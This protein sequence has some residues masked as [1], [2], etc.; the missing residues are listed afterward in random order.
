MWAQ[1]ADALTLDFEQTNILQI[2]THLEEAT[3]LKEGGVGQPEV[4][5]V[6]IALPEGFD[7]EKTWPVLFTLVTGDPY[8]SNLKEMEVYR[9]H[10][11][12]K[13]WVVLTAQ[14]HPWPDR[15]HDTTDG[16]RAAAWAGFRALADLF[17]A[18]T[19]WPTAFAG[20]SGGSKMS[21]RLAG[22]FIARGRDVVGVLMIGCNEDAS[23]DI[24][25]EYQPG[26]TKWWSTGFFLSSGQRDT[27][28]TAGQMREVRRS[29]LN[30]GARH[31]R[32]ETFKGRH[33]IYR[34]HIDEALDWFAELAREAE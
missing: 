11:V 28:S 4:V 22:D 10:A 5:L 18:S 2:P 16:R 24:L 14:P 9:P 21:Q 1:K 3:I 27:V 25:R 8:R 23:R 30:R 15:E 31:V 32:L 13:G 17:P 29:L 7:P 6:G 26:Q 20:F 34:R 33:Q 19:D 12:A